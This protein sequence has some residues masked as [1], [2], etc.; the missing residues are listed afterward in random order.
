M[1]KSPKRDFNEQSTRSIVKAITY[2]LLI[3]A[4]T[5]IIV[6]IYT[7]DPALTTT[8]TISTTISNSLLYF[9]HERIWNKIKWG[10]QSI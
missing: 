10:K 6:W 5:S 3:I 7:G 9:V 1:P 2:R 4:A 8:I